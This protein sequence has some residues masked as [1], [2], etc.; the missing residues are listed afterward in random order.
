MVAV[1]NFLARSVENR[2]AFSFIPPEPKAL[3]FSK[4]GPVFDLMIRLPVGHSTNMDM[5]PPTDLMHTWA[6][7]WEKYCTS[8]SRDWQKRRRRLQ[9]LEFQ[10]SERR[11]LITS[12]FQRLNNLQCLALL[13]LYQ[14][15]HVLV[16]H[17]CIMVM[18]PLA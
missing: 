7:C 8:E 18:N 12:C 17:G 3:Q 15:R 11:L 4:F 16:C 10:K 1:S 6:P 5:T 13:A 2:T 9:P 14:M